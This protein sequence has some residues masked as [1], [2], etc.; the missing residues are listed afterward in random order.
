M[1]TVLPCYG[2]PK[3]GE[4]AEASKSPFGYKKFCVRKKFVWLWKR[5]QI[6]RLDFDI[7]ESAATPKDHD[8]SEM[9]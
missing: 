6:E 5:I 4:L 7:L 1:E 9:E 8:L 2:G 3:D